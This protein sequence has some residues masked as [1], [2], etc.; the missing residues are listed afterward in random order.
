MPD[1]PLGAPRPIATSSVNIA[2]RV[3]QPESIGEVV[4]EQ[5]I[6][7]EMENEA[8]TDLTSVSVTTNEANDPEVQVITVITDMDDVGLN[9]VLKIWSVVEN[10]VGQ[11]INEESVRIRAT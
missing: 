7:Q 8:F 2:F 6:R 11:P 3:H 10:H 4:I 9:A 1:G 5:L